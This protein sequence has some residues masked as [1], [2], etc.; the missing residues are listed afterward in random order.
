LKILIRVKSAGKRRPVLELTEYTVPDGIS[1][2]EELITAIVRDNVRKYNHKEIDAPLFKYLSKEEL[3]DSA[4]IGKVGFGDRK[5]EKVQDE[6]EAV[7]NALQS[8]HDGLYRMLINNT[9][10]EPETGTVMNPAFPAAAPVATPIQINEGDTLTF[11]RLVLLAGR[12][13]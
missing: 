10:A 2:A 3:E 11:I 1:T 9:E 4:Y 12:R 7:E 5:N 6:T 8:F 13:W